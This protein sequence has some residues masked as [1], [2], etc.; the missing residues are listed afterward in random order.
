MF[1]F[2]SKIP[3]KVVRVRFTSRVIARGIED[4]IAMGREIGSE[5][6]VD[7]ATADALKGSVQYL[8]AVTADGTPAKR[9]KAFAPAEY[10]GESMPMQWKE[11]PACFASFWKLSQELRELRFKATE[12]EGALR[13]A[14]SSGVGNEG[15]GAM[16]DAAK[17]FMAA[18]DA[19]S[20][21]NYEPI[22][23]AYVQCGDVAISEIRSVEGTR[24]ALERL[25]FAIFQARAAALELNEGHALRLFSG[26]ALARK[27]VLPR[28]AESDMRSAGNGRAYMDAPIGAIAQRVFNARERRVQLAALLERA[29]AELAAAS[30]VVAPRGNQFVAA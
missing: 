24:A 6:D 13:A 11:L 19:V 16:S 26:S 25:A 8:G 29:K 21:H 28:I 23:R 5:L 4:S 10:V 7:Q 18:R 27:Y 30:I 2:L 3:S 22:Q 15:E 1:D 14:G 17:K 12:A 20:S 9:K